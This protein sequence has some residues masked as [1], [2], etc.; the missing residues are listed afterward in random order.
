MPHPL[1]TTAYADHGA[2]NEYSL[3]S[4]SRKRNEKGFVK[5]KTVG[6][7]H[8]RENST[9]SAAGLQDSITKAAAK[10]HT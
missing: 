7:H 8:T 6:G 1:T 3:R 4:I 5:Q 9:G 2:K 10:Q